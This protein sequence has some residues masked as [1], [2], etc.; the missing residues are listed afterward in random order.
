MHMEGG[1]WCYNED[2]CLQRSKTDLGSSKNWQPK[3]ELSG[4]L[5]DDPHFNPI[6]YNWNVIFLMYC[7]GASFTGNA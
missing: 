4:F 6:F 3:T 7:D 2:A 5:S 1:G